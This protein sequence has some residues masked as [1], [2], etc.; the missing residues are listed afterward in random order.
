MKSIAEILQSAGEI[1]GKVESSDRMAQTKAIVK[2]LTNNF[3]K[4]Y[5][6]AKQPKQMD[7]FDEDYESFNERM[8]RE[9][10]D[11]WTT[12][13][14][15]LLAYERYHSLSIRCIRDIHLNLAKGLIL[16]ADGR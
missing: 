4:G 11:G 5:Q 12:Y 3:N 7:L 8:R 13:G 16:T 1:A 10:T 9:D 2:G 6:K 15:I 14:Y